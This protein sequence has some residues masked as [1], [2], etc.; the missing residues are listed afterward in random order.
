MGKEGSIAA[1]TWVL[2]H[3]WSEAPDSR[4]S[5]AEPSLTHG[6]RKLK[7]RKKLN[8]SGCKNGDGPSQQRGSGKVLSFKSLLRM[9]RE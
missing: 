3:P 6:V 4:P 1:V 8:K 7:E 2:R 9:V 5:D